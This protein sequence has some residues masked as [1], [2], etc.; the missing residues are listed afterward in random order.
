MSIEAT[1]W[2]WRQDPLGDGVEIGP[3]LK[4]VL[5]ALADNAHPSDGYVAISHPALIALDVSSSASLVEADLRRLEALR[6]LRDVTNDHD[7]RIPDGLQAFKL[8]VEK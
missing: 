7:N 6:L 2:A 1:S 4:L 3:R 5:L 8:M